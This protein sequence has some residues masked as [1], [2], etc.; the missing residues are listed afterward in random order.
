LEAEALVEPVRT[1][2]VELARRR[3]ARAAEA[4][5][6]ALKGSEELLYRPKHKRKSRKK[7]GEARVLNQTDGLHV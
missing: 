7:D 3:L 1:M 2:V 6:G 4:K 5:P